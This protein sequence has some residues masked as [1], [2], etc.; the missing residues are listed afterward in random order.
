MFPWLPHW[1]L[2]EFIWVRAAGLLVC[3][4]YLWI[5][6]IVWT[7]NQWESKSPRFLS[8]HVVCMPELYPWVR[9]LWDKKKQTETGDSDVAQWRAGWLRD[10]SAQG[11]L[12]VS[13]SRGVLTDISSDSGAIGKSQFIFSVFQFEEIGVDR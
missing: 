11:E 10:G 1:V 5:P 13:Q 8:A 9:F 12:M 4:C 6:Y 3:E 7:A 2:L